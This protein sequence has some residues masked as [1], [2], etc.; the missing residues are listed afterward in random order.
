MN[1]Q[2]VYW[3]KKYTPRF[4]QKFL[5]KI[6][7]EKISYWKL[8]RISKKNIDFSGHGETQAVKQYLKNDSLDFNYFVDIGA[9]DGVSSSSTLE[10]AKMPNWHGLSIEYDDNKFSKL[11]YV[12]R[13]YKNISLANKKVTPDSIVDI[14]HDYEVPKNFSFLNID[15]DSY[16]LE[17]SKSLFQL[18]YRP[19]IV[20]IE[21]NEK[22]PPPIYFN[23]KYDQ[24]HFWQGD[25]FF[26]CSLTAAIE[27]FSKFDYLLAEFRLNNAIFVNLI[28]FP[29]LTPKNASIAYEEGYKSIKNRKELFKYNHDVEILHELNNDEKIVFINNLFKKYKNMYELKIGDQNE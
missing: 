9:S 16:D 14:L 25:H 12:Y 24:E 11:Q 20:S 15:I 27:E 26:G 2:M 10:F 4:I 21:I 22:I 18:G 17:V 7:P 13:K 19:D 8:D 23:V 28:K 1:N 3:Y 5:K 6:E 29:E